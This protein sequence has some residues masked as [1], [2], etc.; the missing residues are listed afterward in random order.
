MGGSVLPY[1]QRGRFR[2]HVRTTRRWRHRQCDRPSRRHRRLASALNS[3][4]RRRA[5]VYDH[6]SGL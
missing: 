4:R 3:S 2:D 5:I 6:V 1:A